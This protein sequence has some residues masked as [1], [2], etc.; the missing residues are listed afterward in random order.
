MEHYLELGT[1]YLRNGQKA[2]ALGVLNNAL[3]HHPNA[4]RILEAIK[5]ASGASR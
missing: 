3:L 2:K 5:A 4:P 1:L